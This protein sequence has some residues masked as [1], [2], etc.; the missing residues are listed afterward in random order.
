M[1]TDGEIEYLCGLA[2]TIDRLAAMPNVTIASNGSWLESEE[3]GSAE[4]D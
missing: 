2:S 1:F 4:D 3:H